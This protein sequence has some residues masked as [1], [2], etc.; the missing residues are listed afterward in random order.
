MQVVERRRQIEVEEQE[1]LRKEKVCM[2]S[3][4]DIVQS[5]SPVR[6]SILQS[7]N[8]ICVVYNA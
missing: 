2:T 8:S 6:R 1:V 4:N 3:V 5:Y 7:I